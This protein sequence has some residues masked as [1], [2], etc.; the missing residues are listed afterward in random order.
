MTAAFR[1][2]D[3]AGVTVGDDGQTVYVASLPAGPLVVLEGAAAVIWSEATGESAA[4]WVARVAGAVGQ[5]EADIAADV[6]SFVDDLCERGLLQRETGEGLPDEE[7][8]R[9]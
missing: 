3:D 5:V 8:R 1:V 4:G 7:S 9:A 6:E 2:S